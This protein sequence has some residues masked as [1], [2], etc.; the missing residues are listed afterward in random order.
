MI[1]TPDYDDYDD[2]EPSY[3]RLLDNYIFSWIKINENGTNLIEYFKEISAA[4]LISYCF[5]RI[6]DLE[7]LVPWIEMNIR[8]CDIDLIKE[9][10]LEVRGDYNKEILTILDLR[11]QQ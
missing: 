10:I 11:F 4:N 7:R 9:V 3:W 6:E 2:S 5:Q 1:D 8:R